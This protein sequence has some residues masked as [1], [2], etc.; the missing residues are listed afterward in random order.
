MLI[1]DISF[2]MFLQPPSRFH[3]SSKTCSASSLGVEQRKL[4][5]SGER[6]RWVSWSSFLVANVLGFLLYY[7]YKA[8]RTFVKE[9]VTEEGCEPA[10]VTMMVCISLGW[11]FSYFDFEML[12]LNFLDQDN[13]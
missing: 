2:F 4:D 8:K 10:A 12:K 13:R 3:T 5:P 6:R 9:E 7:Q 11:G 1:A